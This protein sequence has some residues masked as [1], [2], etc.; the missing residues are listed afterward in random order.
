MNATIHKAPPPRYS[1]PD[2]W[3]HKREAS[4]L[5]LI[6][7]WSVHAVVRAYEVPESTVIKWKQ[8]ANIPPHTG[9]KR[10]MTDV[11]QILT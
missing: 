10:P 5:A 8:A 2:K 1:S 6:A 7:G 11:G 9:P 4:V 3:E